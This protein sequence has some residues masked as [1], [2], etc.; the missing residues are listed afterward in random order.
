MTLACAMAGLRSVGNQR[1]CTRVV[2]LPMALFRVCCFAARPRAAHS[3]SDAGRH[4]RRHARQGAE[5]GY[6]CSTWNVGEPGLGAR[7][8]CLG[9]AGVLRVG[10]GPRLRQGLGFEPSCRCARIRG[11]RAPR[12]GPVR[13]SGSGMQSGPNTLAVRY[14][15]SPEGCFD[16]GLVVPEGRGAPPWWGAAACELSRNRVP[17]S[18]CTL[19]ALDVMTE[20]IVASAVPP[21][22][23]RPCS[24]KTPLLPAVSIPAASNPPIAPGPACSAPLALPAS[25]VPPPAAPSPDPSVPPTAPVVRPSKPPPRLIPAPPAAPVIAP[26]SPALLA[27]L[28]SA[29][30]IA[31][32]PR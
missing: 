8:S 14:R 20:P 3:P 1:R 16:S 19:F 5:C 7:S 2:V 24:P 13:L 28:A 29:A 11:R 21:E 12:Q 27:A 30:A 22:R 26:A 4:P 31:W 23:L 6:R 15:R 9:F 10:T 25:E 32:I 18:R 17:W